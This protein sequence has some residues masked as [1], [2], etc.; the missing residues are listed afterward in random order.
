VSH[1]W[2][3]N[4]RE[5]ENTIIRGIYLNESGTIE[6]PDIGLVFPNSTPAKSD[7]R[8]PFRVAKQKAVEAFERAYLARLMSEHG[9]N[10]SHA[11]QAAGKDRRDL[12][13]LPKKYQGDTAISH[14]RC[15]L[16]P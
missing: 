14:S 9:G 2:R 15:R 11:A 3:G 4:I 13:K 10:V 6:L 1:E 8:Q 5:L 12:G 16:T 7:G